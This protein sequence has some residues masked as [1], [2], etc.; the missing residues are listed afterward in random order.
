MMI[1]GGKGV[2]VQEKEEEE[3][4]ERRELRNVRDKP[5]VACPILHPSIC[6]PPLPEYI[7]DSIHGSGARGGHLAVS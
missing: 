6:P 3:E 2:C 5:C 1:I 7:L 4:E